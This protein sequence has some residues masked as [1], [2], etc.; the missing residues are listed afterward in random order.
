MDLLDPSAMVFRP[1]R[2]EK[3]KKSNEYGRLR[4]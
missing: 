4:V 2:K 1:E 3:L